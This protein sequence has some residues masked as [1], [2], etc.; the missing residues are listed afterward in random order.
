MVDRSAT[1]HGWLGYVT[2]NTVPI[3]LGGAGALTG[4]MLLSGKVVDPYSLLINGAV[5]GGGIFMGITYLQC[6]QC[7]ATKNPDILGCLLQQGA[8]NAV[9]FVTGVVAGIAD[10]VVP[11]SGKFVKE[12]GSDLKLWA[13]D[14]SPIGIAYD[15]AMAVV[16][17]GKCLAKGDIKCA[18]NALWDPI[19]GRG[20]DAYYAA[21]S[22]ANL[23]GV[24]D[25]FRTASNTIADGA[26]KVANA[27]KNTEK[28]LESSEKFV[29]KESEKAA[30]K[31][32][33]GVEDTANTIGK[34]TADTAKKVA[35]TAK[36]A[37]EGVEGAAKKV[38]DFFK[39]APRPPTVIHVPPGSVVTPSMIAAGR[40]SNTTY[41]VDAAPSESSIAASLGRLKDLVNRGQRLNPDDQKAWN[42]W[43]EAIR[44]GT[45]QNPVDDR[46]R[47]LVRS[48]ARLNKVDQ[49]AWDNLVKKGHQW[50]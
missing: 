36:K 39:P 9:D 45:Y 28:A 7:S 14:A 11:G 49:K 16:N 23:I 2:D 48:G 40:M 44:I 26:T 47:N 43:V 27:A 17:G 5:T 3:S 24:G 31:V 1:C 32:A 6:K 15:G 30:K 35:D 4:L 19:K 46:L 22:A 37:A 41:V 33:T 34:G 50:V 29:A 8:N 10:S 13:R 25:E 12:G 42:N 21:K 20:K 18:G 38:G